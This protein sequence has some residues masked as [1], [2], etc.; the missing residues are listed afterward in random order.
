M[1][2]LLEMVAKLDGNCESLD[3][4]VRQIRLGDVAMGGGQG[5]EQRGD[6]EN[7][8]WHG[9]EGYPAFILLLLSLPG[10]WLLLY[11]E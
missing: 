3:F 9:D 1:D 11:E 5:R 6:G 7:G 2:V 8:L 10:L 4:F